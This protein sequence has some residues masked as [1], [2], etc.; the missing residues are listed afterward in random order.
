MGIEEEGRTGR[1]EGER[2]K[3]MREKEREGRTRWTEG[4][5]RDV[6]RVA[7]G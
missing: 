2:E 3:A 7:K 5:G 6:K 1:K 4:E